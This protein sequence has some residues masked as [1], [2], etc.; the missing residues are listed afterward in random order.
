MSPALFQPE[1]TA[2]EGAAVKVGAESVFSDP[3]GVYVGR[4]PIWVPEKEGEIVAGGKG[5]EAE[6]VGAR[7]PAPAY[8]KRFN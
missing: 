5:C 7:V 1:P 8:E 4:R 2:T 3:V 6:A